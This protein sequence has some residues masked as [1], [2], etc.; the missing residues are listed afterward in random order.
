MN[1]EKYRPNVCADC[2][3]F[4]YGYWPTTGSAYLSITLCKHPTNCK[5]KESGEE[6]YFIR[7]EKMEDTLIYGECREFNGHGQ[8]TLWEQYVPEIYTHRYWSEEEDRYID[9]EK[10]VHSLSLFHKITQWIHLKLAGR[11]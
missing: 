8:C 5:I 6:K 2:K 9:G 7:G 10:P 11:R 4:Y 3:Y 1:E